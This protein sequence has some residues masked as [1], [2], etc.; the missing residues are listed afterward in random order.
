MDADVLTT[1]LMIF[2]IGAPMEDKSAKKSSKGLVE[3]A[4]ASRAQRAPERQ[5]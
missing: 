4:I 1:G 2:C 3:C 5:S